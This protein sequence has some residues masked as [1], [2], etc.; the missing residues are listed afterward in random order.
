MQVLRQQLDRNGRVLDDGDRPIRPAQRGQARQRR[1]AH[2]PKAV[3]F[4]RI[5]RRQR[6]LRPVA[7]PEAV[8]Q[9]EGE[10]RASAGPSAS[11]STSSTA[12]AAAGTRS[13]EPSPRARRSSRR[14]ISSQATGP[15]A[16]D[17]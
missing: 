2:A 6:Q 11:Y 16:R 14:S 13:A 1:L 7:L 15:V 3:D 5:G 17:A 12:S 8:D 10:R 4:F 9:V